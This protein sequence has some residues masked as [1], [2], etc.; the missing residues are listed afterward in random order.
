MNH[1]DFHW[2][3][4]RAPIRPHGPPVGRRS[5]RLVR[6]PGCCRHADRPSGPGTPRAAPATDMQDVCSAPGTFRRHVAPGEGHFL[7]K[8]LGRA[9]TSPWHP[10]IGMSGRFRGSGLAVQKTGSERAGRADRRRSRSVSGILAGARAADC[11]PGVTTVRANPGA[12]LVDR[13]LT[14]TTKGMITNFG[15]HALDLRFRV[16]AGAR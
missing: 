4:W 13:P 8:P 11:P 5:C 3:L 9:A 14:R 10:L 7:T 1:L 16:V 6:S 15:D 2:E 12:Y